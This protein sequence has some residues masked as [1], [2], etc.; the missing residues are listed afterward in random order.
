MSDTI[1]LSTSD[2]ADKLNITYRSAQRL[3]R[4]YMQHIGSDI[5]PRRGR[6]LFQL[7]TEQVE[8]ILQLQQLADRTTIPY[9]T[10]L[11]LRNSPHLTDLLTHLTEHNPEHVGPLSSSASSIQDDMQ[12]LREQT[13]HIL[14]GVKAITAS[15]SQ[16]AGP[17]ATPAPAPVRRDS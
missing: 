15:L 16:N 11:T 12:Y 14:V 3:V 10:L 1:M 9:E 4:L 8:R 5:Q 2:V 17:T 6:A 13:T 7:T